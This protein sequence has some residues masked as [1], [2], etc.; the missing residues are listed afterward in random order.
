MANAPSF[1]LMF[2]IR[3]TRMVNGL[4]PIYARISVNTNRTEFAIKRNI[5]PNSWNP[6]RGMAKP[7][8]REANEINPYLEKIRKRIL[9]CHSELLLAGKEISAQLI[10]QLFFGEE[11]QTKRS[12]DLFEYHNMTFQS[13]LAP[14]TF[15]HYLTTQKYFN[16]FL[17]INFH[18]ESI[19]LDSI[20]Y[21]FLTDFE[22][23]LRKRSGKDKSENMANNTTMKHF[24]RLRKMLNLAERLQWLLKNPFKLYKLQYENRERGFLYDHQLATIEE[25]AFSI[26]RLRVVRDLF[27]FSCYT[28]IPYGDLQLLTTENIIQGI[29]GNLW[30]SYSRQKTGN[31]VRLPILPKVI[32]IIEKYSD[33]PQLASPQHLMPKISNQKMNS[34]LKEI[35]DLCGIRMNLTFHIARHTFAT[36]VTLSN[37]VPIETV[38][39]VLGHT[40]ISTTQIYAKVV[41][42]KISDDLMDLYNKMDKKENDKK[43]SQRK[44]SL[45][46]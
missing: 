38:S 14:G 28:G 22:F 37:G 43:N 33:H 40:K 5:N 31:D 30:L 36:T 18:Q 41:E 20:D 15:K 13:R 19:R 25:K 34:Y 21:R 42:Q 27:V 9:D 3:N 12:S 11:E 39:K 2:I 16:E 29:D 32:Q 7:K 24:C 10:K 44:I 23:F 8:T 17:S 45:L 1:S 4:A 26:E 6:D 35:A 46:K